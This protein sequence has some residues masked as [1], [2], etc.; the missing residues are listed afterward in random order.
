VGHLGLA[1]RLPEQ[2]AVDVDPT[3]AVV[4]TFNRP[5]VPLG[6]DPESLSPAFSLEPASE[7]RGEWLNTSTYVFYPDLALAG[8]LE[9]TVRLESEL[10]GTDGSPLVGA[11]SWSFSTAPPHLVYVEPADEAD[12][13]RLDTDIVLTFNQPMDADSAEAN[14]ALLDPDSNSVPGEVG[15]NDDFTVLTFSPTNLLRRDKRYIIMV[16][17]QTQASGGT[18]LGSEILTS[19]HTVPQLRVIGSEPLEGGL[20]NIYAGVNVY[21]NGPIQFQNVEQFTTFIPELPN[22]QVFM[23]EDERIGDFAPGTDYTLIVSPNL[24]DA[25]SGRLGQEFILNF[26]TQPLDPQ[27]FLSVGTDV[28]FLTPHDSSL[29]AQVT[30]LS[31]LSMSMGS[32][33]PEDF[34]ALLAPGGYDLRQSYQPSDQINIWKDLDLPPNQSQ[35]VEIPLMLEG[36]LLEPGLYFL[37]FNLDVEHIFAGPYLMVVSNVNLAYKL[38]ATD[39]LVW[40][41]DMRDGTPVADEPVTIYAEDGVALAN[42]V[43]DANGVFHAPI[44]PREDPYSTNY[45]VLGQPGQERFSLALSNWNQGLEG[46]DFGIPTDFSPPRLET[47]IY[48]DRPIYRP[49]Q[50]VFF[51]AVARKAYN[52]RYRQRYIP[53]R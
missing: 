21:F 35:V 19:L 20:R 36:E 29:N 7:G 24:P 51:R 5:V 44:P 46:W 48:T 42:G 41:V 37:R 30:N 2:G 15:W 11:D 18:P 25:W 47:Y 22:Q 1:Q 17:G 6:A 33:P 43:T 13:V 14:F 3:S 45:A 39:A 9:Y 49:G 23:D 8:G 27:V 53:G 34:W 4:A 10:S 52:G 40:A 16:D 50:T 32:V 26:H 28:L 38:S 31:K 12:D